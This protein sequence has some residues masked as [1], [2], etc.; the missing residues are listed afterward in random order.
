MGWGRGRGAGARAPAWDRPQALSQLT[1]S[2]AVLFP[3]TPQ[4]GLPLTPGT[5][6]PRHLALLG[7]G[8][9]ASTPL[10]YFPVVR[11]SM[12]L[13]RP[14]SKKQGSYLETLRRGGLPAPNTPSF[15]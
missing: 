11:S 6:P 2:P 14:T 15:T 13:Q 7:G 10:L 8:C 9:P 3:G 1:C 5:S 4:A 12:R